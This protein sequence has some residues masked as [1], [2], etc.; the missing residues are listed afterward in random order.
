LLGSLLRLGLDM[1]I[2]VNET[3][4]IK[5]TSYEKNPQLSR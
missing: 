4:G 3:H 5:V 1:S 2:L